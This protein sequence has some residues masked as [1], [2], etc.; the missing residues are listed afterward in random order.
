MPLIDI[1]SIDDIEPEEAMRFDHDGRTYAIFRNDRE[2]FFCT[3]GL[4][5]HE[6]VHLAEGLVMG[7]TVE[8][9]KHASIFDFTSGEAE[10]PPACENLQTFVTRIVD[11]RVFAE[12]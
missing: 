9:P 2:Q 5:T 4:C 11:G 8:C 1:C 7:N 6:E 12:I 10:T 3:S